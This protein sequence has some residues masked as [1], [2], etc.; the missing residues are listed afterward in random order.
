MLRNR[1]RTLRVPG[2]CSA[3]WHRGRRNV[4]AQVVNLNAHGMLLRTDETIPVNQMMDLVVHL[5]TG[6]V[7]FMAV[8]RYVGETRWGHGIG[9]EIRVASPADQVRWTMHYREV[10][11]RRMPSPR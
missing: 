6:D 1:R 10:S 8:S 3:D 9:V 5:P 11:A 4:A 2:G 7:S